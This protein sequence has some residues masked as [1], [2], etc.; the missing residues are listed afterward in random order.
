[1][2]L[3]LLIP[4]HSSIKD[5]VTLMK[6]R[7]SNSTLQSLTSPLSKMPTLV[8]VKKKMMMFQLL[9]RHQFQMRRI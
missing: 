3:A 5:Q 6:T 9:W 7:L 8:A 2:K 4:T 1:M